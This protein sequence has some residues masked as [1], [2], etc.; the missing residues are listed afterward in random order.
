MY[1]RQSKILFEDI[2]RK[3][4]KELQKFIFLLAC[5]NQLA[6]EK[7]YRN[8][9]E[10]AYKNLKYLKDENKIKSW[11]FS[12]AKKEAS[13]YYATNRA[14]YDYATN[15]LNEEIL[16]MDENEDF[17][18]Y[19]VDLNLVKQIIKAF[20]EDIQQIFLLHYYYDMSLTEISE[21]LHIDYETVEFIHSRGL[22]Q[23]RDSFSVSLGTI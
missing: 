5:K 1:D 9:M 8:T 15:E 4:G 3:H 22:S 17:T 11:V 18:P 12:I 16:I 2:C 23:L 14:H 21:T 10:T 13:R 19:V 6:M 20:S 7:I